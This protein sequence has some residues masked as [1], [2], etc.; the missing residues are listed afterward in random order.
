MAKLKKKNK[1][2]VG[3]Q[4]NNKIDGIFPDGMSRTHD[5]NCI[6]AIVVRNFIN[7]TTSK[8]CMDDEKSIFCSQK[9]PNYKR[10]Y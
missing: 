1:N 7:L 3:M 9:T 2:I 8:S 4:I 10:K 5:L 6:W